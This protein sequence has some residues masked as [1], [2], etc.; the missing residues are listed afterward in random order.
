SY[1]AKDDD[2][3]KDNKQTTV[4]ITGAIEK[5][6]W[7]KNTANTYAA[8]K[9]WPMAYGPDLT[10]GA[11]DS[12][13]PLVKSLHD[14]RLVWVADMPIGSGRGGGLTRGEFAMFPHSWNTLWA[15]GFGGPTMADDKVFLYAPQPD[16]AAIKN[17][18]KLARNPYYRLGAEPGHFANKLGH[19]REAV[20]AFDARTGTVLW[21]YLGQPGTVAGADGKGGRASSPCYYQGQ[22][23][24]RM[25][26]QIICLDAESGEKIWSIGGFGLKGAPGDASVTQIGGTLIVT[27]TMKGGW[28]TVG[29]SPKDGSTIWSHDYIGGGGSDQAW[30]GNSIPGLY[31]ENGK[32]YA[33]MGRSAPVKK[34]KYEKEGI[35]V[36]PATFVMI[37]PVD[38]T[39]LWESDALAYN[40]SQIVVVGDI[41]IG[42]YMEESTQKMKHPQQAHRIAGVQISTKGAKRIWTQPAVNPSK[43]RQM[44]IAH[45]GMYFSDSRKT[46]FTAKDVQSGALLGKKRGI[47][48][49]SQVSHNW[50]WQIASNNRILTEGLLMFDTTDGALDLMTGRLGNS[51]SG[52][53]MAPT[54]PLIADGRIIYRMPDKLV[55]YDLRQTAETAK[56]EVITLTAKDAVITGP[57]KSDIEIRIRKRGD[58]LISL[59]GKAPYLQASADMKKAVPWWPQDW[60]NLSWYRTVDP[61][62]VTL[63]DEQLSGASLVAV[64]YNYEPFTFELQRDGD[65][66]AG[67]YTR[68][69]RAFDQPIAVEGIVK[70]PLLVEEDGHRVFVFNLDKAGISVADLTGDRI[71]KAGVWL[72][73]TVNKDNELIRMIAHADRVNR[74]THEVAVDSFVVNG[75]HV[76]ATVTVLTHD[77]KYGDLDVVPT[78]HE[79]RSVGTG[80]AVAMRY[81]I[82]TLG[83]EVKDEKSGESQMQNVGTYTGTIG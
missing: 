18:P 16:I 74:M 48:T 60:S 44:N 12:D 52:G 81:E 39:I 65:A 28:Q 38:G 68:T 59:A 55:C 19:N 14:A 25:G 58:D 11:I 46:G 2:Y 3:G 51:V 40:D 57:L 83:T 6:Y 45:H 67:T 37:D 62:D 47:Y 27:R 23:F 34:F 32:E 20:M 26:G 50:S 35:P 75:N 33:V 21:Q 53:Y 13:Q 29:L 77:D 43:Y 42:N 70:G 79:F 8:G 66:F 5:D 54:K 41:A 61:V 63:N 24:V 31:R 80:G 22:V 17:D 56:T 36:P 49:L 73:A 76:K 4:S 9:D 7:E 72:V 10:G 69:V 71:P 82:E 64:G 1:A 78:Q 15:S 30:P